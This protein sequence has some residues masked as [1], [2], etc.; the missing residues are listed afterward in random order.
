MWEFLRMIKSR[1]KT[2]HILRRVSLKF[3]KLSGDGVVK[4]QLPGVKS[5]PANQLPAGVVE[6][7]SDEG[8]AKIQHMN[9][10]LVGPACFKPQ[11]EQADVRI[12][13][14]SQKLIVGN[15]RIALFKIHPALQGRARLP[16][17]GG[18]DGAGFVGLSLYD[19]QIGFFNLALF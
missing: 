14:V 1:K 7:I 13:P 9:P 17:N 3:Q 2:G 19:G 8:M 5:L 18:A 6:K 12:R 11:G 16:G 4:L 15:G 10:D